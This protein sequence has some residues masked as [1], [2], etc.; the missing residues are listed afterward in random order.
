M[1]IS[2]RIDIPTP[3]ERLLGCRTEREFLQRQYKGVYFSTDTRLFYIF[4]S[5]FYLKGEYDLLSR[6][7]LNK[8]PRQ[9]AKIAKTI[10]FGGR[11]PE[12]ERR[13]VKYIKQ[14]RN[15]AYL[16]VNPTET[17]RFDF[18]DGEKDG[19]GQIVAKKVNGK[20]V[21]LCPNQI[22]EINRIIFCFE[23]SVSQRPEIN[24]ID[25]N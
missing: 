22:L 5:N 3:L 25:F 10:D 16:T 19:D 20:L 18:K 23:G 2:E 8:Y 13:S 1:F 15:E 12:F 21:H 6:N 24:S 7:F 9:T 14:G 11:H 4:I 17:Y